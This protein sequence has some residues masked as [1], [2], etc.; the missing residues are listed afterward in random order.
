MDATL[1]IKCG[2]MESPD[3]RK[4]TDNLCQSLNQEVGMEAALGTRSL[5]RQ[6][7]VIGG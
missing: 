4:M 5:R 7:Y 3:F 2:E 6:S 1:T